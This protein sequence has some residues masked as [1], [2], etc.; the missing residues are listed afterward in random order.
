MLSII[1]KELLDMNAGNFLDRHE[2]ELD[3]MLMGSKRVAEFR[4]PNSEVR[5]EPPQEGRFNS[6]PKKNAKKVIIKK[7][8]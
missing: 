2:C 6:P 4:R 5:F 1:P 3:E 7:K 8:Q